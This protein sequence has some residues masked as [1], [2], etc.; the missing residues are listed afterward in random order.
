MH[1]SEALKSYQVILVPKDKIIGMRSCMPSPSWGE[2]IEAV[3]MWGTEKKAL[4][5]N[6]DRLL[7]ISAA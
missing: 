2:T 1:F 3:S 6:A 5:G 4:N 7:T